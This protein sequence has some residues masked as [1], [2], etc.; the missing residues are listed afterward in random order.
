MN[1]ATKAG[2]R[3]P[4]N[5]DRLSFCPFV[6]QTSIIAGVMVMGLAGNG[7]RRGREGW[8]GGREGLSFIRTSEI[9]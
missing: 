4:A 9:P 1:A 8:R 6:Q 3:E 2:Y 5:P 7:M